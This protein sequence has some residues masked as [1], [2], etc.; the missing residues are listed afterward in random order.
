MIEGN[1]I[2]KTSLE[3]PNSRSAIV[4]STN[5]NGVLIKDNQIL[6]SNNKYGI[7][8]TSTCLNIQSF[9][10]NAQGIEGAISIPPNSG[11]DGLVI[12]NNISGT[13]YR[14]FITEDGKPEFTEWR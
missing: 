1:I 7:S 12:N 2:R 4:L 13:R 10:N 3:T 14:M 6:L 5:C 8:V 9:N 11:F